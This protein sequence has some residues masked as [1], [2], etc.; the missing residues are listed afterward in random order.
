LSYSQWWKRYF[1]SNWGAVFVIAFMAL[2]ILAAVEMAYGAIDAANSAAL[3]AFYAL[4]IGV[5]LQM[6]YYVKH[7]GIESREFPRVAPQPSPHPWVNW[8]RR[9]K[10]IAVSIT[11]VVLVSA[12]ALL[13]LEYPVVQEVAFHRSYPALTASISF[14]NTVK[15]PDGTVVVNVGVSETG[16]SL[17]YM[18]IA[19]W[20]DG[21]IQNNTLGTFSRTFLNQTIPS[22]VTVEITSAD[23]QNVTLNANIQAPS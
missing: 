5:A 20:P 4:V 6:A 14:T 23:R 22:Y 9:K 15:E 18:F 19:K 8:N 2:L 13:Y 17:P 21:I 12:G 7:G 1:L 16:G 10:L 3:A 11:V